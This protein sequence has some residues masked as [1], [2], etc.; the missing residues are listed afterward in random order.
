MCPHICFLLRLKYMWVSIN[1]DP[2]WFNDVEGNSKLPLQGQCHRLALQEWG[3]CCPSWVLQ[4][5]QHMAW[6]HNIVGTFQTEKEL[7]RLKV[8]VCHARTAHALPDLGDMLLV[9]QPLGLSRGNALLGD[10]GSKNVRNNG[11]REVSTEPLE[12]F[13]FSEEEG[14]SGPAMF[15][16]SNFSGTGCSWTP[17]TC[18][19]KMNQI[20]AHYR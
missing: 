18:R 10:S 12:K 5:S 11:E 6:L 8:R 2:K 16:Y 17:V 15:K 20:L 14:M 1:S 9:W 7:K 3:A 4:S 13:P 19:I